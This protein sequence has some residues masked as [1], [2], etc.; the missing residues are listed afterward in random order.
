MKFALMQQPSHILV[1]IVDIPR[2]CRYDPPPGVEAQQVVA[3]QGELLHLL[4]AVCGEVSSELVHT[5]QHRPGH[6]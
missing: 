3:R 2:Y 4:L 5:R 6:R 1:D